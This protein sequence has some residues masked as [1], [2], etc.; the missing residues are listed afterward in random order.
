MEAAHRHFRALT[1]STVGANGC[2]RK[3]MATQ[4]LF[5]TLINLLRGIL[6]SDPMRDND[7]SREKS[8]G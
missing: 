8:A 1:D 4:S 5:K 7:M 6:I 3:R 2:E